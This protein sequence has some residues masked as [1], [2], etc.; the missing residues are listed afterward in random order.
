[1]AIVQFT[2]FKTDKSE[3]MIPR[4]WRRARKPRSKNIWPIG[5]ARGGGR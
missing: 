3:E 2:R 4:S 5:K 1:M